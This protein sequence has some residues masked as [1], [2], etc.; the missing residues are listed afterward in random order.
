MLLEPTYL[1]LTRPDLLRFDFS[2]KM[3][4]S[5]IT[6]TCAK[7]WWAATLPRRW[8]PTMVING[9]IT[10]KWA[11]TWVTRVITAIN[12]VTTIHTTG[13][14]PCNK[15]IGGGW[16]VPTARQDAQCSRGT[17]KTIKELNLS[18]CGWMAFEQHMTWTMSHP[19]SWRD[20]SWSNGLS[21]NAYIT[22]LI[23]HIPL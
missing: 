14:G 13:S 21:N 19:G 15:I 1:Q 10:T 17:R 16:P 6:K 8:A 2:I 20:P 22:L 12:G 23:K 4:I 7:S 5:R 18:C 9:V 11:Y 3:L